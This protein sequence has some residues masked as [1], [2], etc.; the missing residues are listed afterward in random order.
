MHRACAIFFGTC[1]NFQWMEY[2]KVYF[3]HK[4]TE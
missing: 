1:M 3:S 2:S 4:A